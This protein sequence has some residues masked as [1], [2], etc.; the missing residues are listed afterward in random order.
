MNLILHT[1]QLLFANVHIGHSSKFFNLKIKGYLLGL[2]KKLFILNINLTIIQY[3]IVI[4]LII[5]LIS[6]RHKILVIKEF[7][8]SNFKKHL[9]F[10]N[11]M[12]YDKK[13]IGGLLTN[14]KRV[15][16]SP[17]LNFNNDITKIKNYKSMPSVILF[18]DINIS[19]WAL[20]E[21]Y[22]L[23]IPSISLIDTETNNF[24]LL[25][26]PIISNNKS[27]DSTL[28]Y[29]YTIKN[30]II[31][32]QQKEIAKILQL[33][34]SEKTRHIN[35]YLWKKIYRLKHEYKKRIK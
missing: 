15:I 16:T 3:Q 12:F 25:N 34:R 5:N 28:L 26:Y 6:K 18:F 2:R 22:N 24:N 8:L 19:K 32:G 33:N 30:S 10:K 20:L 17:K 11:V 4:N 23:Q 35:K 27:I 9:K 7:D 13:W 1:N 21:A 29:L 31:K 14:Y